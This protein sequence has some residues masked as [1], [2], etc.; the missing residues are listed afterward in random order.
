ML[1]DKGLTAHHKQIMTTRKLEAVLGADSTAL[2]K[3]VAKARLK[4]TKLLVEGGADINTK[5]GEGRSALM[6]ACMLKLPDEEKDIQTRLI[7]LLLENGANVNDID[8][9]G[10]TALI[11]AVSEKAG[12][13][14]VQILLLNKADPRK[15]DRS[16]SSALVH[17]VNAG[18]ADVLAL[19][20]DECKALG[21]EVIIITTKES[22]DAK[23]ET[24]QYL[25]VPPPLVKSPPIFK[26]V[27]PR[28][29]EYR[30]PTS[31]IDNQPKETSL[32][33]VSEFV[34]YKQTLQLPSS[35]IPPPLYKL[36]RRESLGHIDFKTYPAVL[37]EEPE[38]EE[39]GENVLHITC[40][41][42]ARNQKQPFSPRSR[43]PLKRRQSSDNFLLD[44]SSGR[45]DD[46]SSSSL[47]S[48]CQSM[49]SASSLRNRSL[50]NSPEPRPPNSKGLV[51]GRRRRS[52]P[53]MPP[54]L[55]KSQTVHAIRVPGYLL[56][57]SKVA[58]PARS[59]PGDLPDHKLQEE[60]EEE[61]GDES[62]DSGSSLNEVKTS[63]SIDALFPGKFSANGIYRN[64]PIRRGSLPFLLDD[65]L[66]QKRP[67]FLPPLKTN[68]DL[69]IP[70]IGC[71]FESTSENKPRFSR[72]DRRS[73]IQ[74]DDISRL[75][76]MY[77]NLNITKHQSRSQSE[78]NPGE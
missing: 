62:W 64:K 37:S 52:L 35:C 72:L 7:Q 51:G 22:T 8:R 20:V 63:H 54:P 61:T 44:T 11:Y 38:L 78:L 58:S 50:N 3:A 9:H 47:C 32:E 19:L 25:D 70:D 53:G 67:G 5:D 21:K 18:N 13:E 23:R 17:A 30:L 65:E 31:A 71:S 29:I 49:A 73:S 42:E 4:L 41:T 34:E 14:I 66:S 12:P 68:P 48:S 1:I 36:R 74:T 60:D 57:N 27:A 46:G 59:C 39:N 55:R 6:V 24:R 16:G 2:I 76:R 10:K 40:P 77:S 45:L 43:R 26:C 33:D 69:P 75:S 56:E 15:V 28:D